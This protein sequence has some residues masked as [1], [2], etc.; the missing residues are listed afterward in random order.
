MLSAQGPAVPKI[1][2]TANEA[3]ENLENFL[4]KSFPVLHLNICSMSKTLNHF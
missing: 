2:T 3:K 4:E 1:A